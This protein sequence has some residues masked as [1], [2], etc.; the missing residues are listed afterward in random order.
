[1]L[2]NIKARATAIP[3]RQSTGT[4]VSPCDSWGSDDRSDMKI[5]E[6]HIFVIGTTESQSH[7][8]SISRRYTSTACPTWELIMRTLICASIVA[9]GFAVSLSAAQ[10]PEDGPVGR[11]KKGDTI[12]VH[13]CVSG[14]LLKDVRHQKTDAVTGGETS[15]VYRLIGEKKLLRIIQKEHQ[16]Q[17]LEVIGLVESNPDNTSTHTKEMG[18]VRLFVGAGEQETSQPGKPPSYPTLRITSFE[19]LRPHCFV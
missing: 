16:D 19:V 5:P 12:V 13:G 3:E 6:T 10:K 18:R 2:S 9:L 14:S 15:V 7:T 11:S 4:S 1:M 8:L 17:V